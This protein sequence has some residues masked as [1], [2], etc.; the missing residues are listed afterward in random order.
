MANSRGKGGGGDQEGCNWHFESSSMLFGLDREKEMS[1]MVSALTHVVSGGGGDATS[2]VSSD[3][4]SGLGSWTNTTTSGNKRERE[5]HDDASLH[6][7]R[8]SSTAF[9]H[10][11]HPESSYTSGKYIYIYILVSLLPIFLYS[12]FIY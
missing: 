10:L 8:L 5:D 11:S 12:I 6:V 7:S 3:K 2:S 9:G 1:A 4:A